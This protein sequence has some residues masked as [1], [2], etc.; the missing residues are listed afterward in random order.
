MKFIGL[1]GPEGAGKSTVAKMIRDSGPGAEI[2]PFAAPLKRMIAALGVPHESIYGDKAAKELPLAVL[3]GATARHA[4]QTLGTEWG[5]RHMGDSFWLNA[6]IHAVYSSKARLVVAD[7]VRF[8]NEA[9]AILDLGGEIICVVRSVDDYERR[10][11]HASEDFAALPATHR[12]VND[13]TPQQLRD[14]L[15]ACLRGELAWL[16][17]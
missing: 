17:A 13:G 5:R 10:P 12:I 6:W 4:M 3:G 7:D 15:N 8:Y 16:A 1:C 11:K 14:K 2:V 9:Q